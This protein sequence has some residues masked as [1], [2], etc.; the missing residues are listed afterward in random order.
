MSQ[1]DKHK[2]NRFRK[3]IPQSQTDNSN[4]NHRLIS[5]GSDRYI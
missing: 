2:K 5:E 3:L 1:D 4:S